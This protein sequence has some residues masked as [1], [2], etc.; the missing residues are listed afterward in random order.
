MSKIN[1]GDTV[2]VIAKSTA[3]GGIPIGK[4]CEVTEDDGGDCLNFEITTDYTQ[5]YA[6]E[7]HIK[8]ASEKETII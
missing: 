2:I 1:V 4:I 5:G 7:R 8:L 6:D 3:M